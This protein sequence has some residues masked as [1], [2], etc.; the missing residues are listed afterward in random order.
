MNIIIAV[1][2]FFSVYGWLILGS[3]LTFGYAVVLHM[4]VRK[5]MRDC[6]L[7]EAEKPRPQPLFYLGQLYLGFIWPAPLF[8]ILE[9]LGVLN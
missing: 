2:E 3:G 6:T 8:L 1:V 4:M 7:Q 5:V 9:V